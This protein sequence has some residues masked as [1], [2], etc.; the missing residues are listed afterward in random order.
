LL[1]NT[2]LDET[3]LTAHAFRL[4]DGVRIFWAVSSASGKEQHTAFHIFFDI[5][6]CKYPCKVFVP[7]DSKV[8]TI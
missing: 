6:Y 5:G 3:N 2:S 8:I 7:R 4:F 1:Q